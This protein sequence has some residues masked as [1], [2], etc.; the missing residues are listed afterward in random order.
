MQFRLIIGVSHYSVIGD[1]VLCD[2]PIQR[3]RLQRRVLSAMPP[4]LGLSLDCD[5]PFLRKEVGL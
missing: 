2:A 1:I 5:R 4:L 3:D